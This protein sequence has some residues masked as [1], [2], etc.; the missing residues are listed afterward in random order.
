ME[1]VES[2]MLKSKPANIP[3]NNSDISE[4]T[5]KSEYMNTLKSKPES[6]AQNTLNHL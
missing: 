3:P 6:L 2:I 5:L 1:L 4:K